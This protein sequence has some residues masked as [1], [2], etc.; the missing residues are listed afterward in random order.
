MII[1]PLF[2]TFVIQILVTI[3]A[4][5]GKTQAI[6]ELYFVF[7]PSSVTAQQGDS[8]L[9]PCSV[10]GVHPINLTW[11]QGGEEL[12][13]QAG[14]VEILPNGSLSL[15]LSEEIAPGTKEGYQCCAS[16]VFGKL[17]SPAVSI[18]VREPLRKPVI[19]PSC[20]DVALNG[21]I[22]LECQSNASKPHPF[23]W[24][25]DGEDLIQDER[26]T[27]LP[28][29]VLQITPVIWEDGGEYRCITG[30]PATAL[31]TSESSW[32]TVMEELRTSDCSNGTVSEREGRLL[33]QEPE[34]VT[35][36]APV[37]VLILECLGA[38][39]WVEIQW[40]RN[41]EK[42]L[43]PGRSHFTGNKNLKLT[44]L[45][46]DDSG[47]YTCNASDTRTGEVER[48]NAVVQIEDVF[49]PEFTVRPTSD[50]V[51]YFSTARLYCNADGKP[52]PQI[53]WYLNGEPI[54][55]RLI[56]QEMSSSTLIIWNV[57]KEHAGI[58]QCVVSNSVGTIQ[59]SARLTVI[60][61]LNIPDPPYNLT[62]YT[63]DSSQILITWQADEG[64]SLFSLH[65]YIEPDGEETQ[66]VM[67]DEH[68]NTHI[69]KDL[70]PYTN[71]TFY[72]RAY[73][74]VASGISERVLGQTAEGVPVI[75][76]MFSLT[77]SRGNTIFV[78]WEPITIVAL[79]RGCIS[80]YRVCY[81]ESGLPRQYTC[82]EV[83]GSESS[84]TLRG[85]KP[86][87]VYD[88]HMAV[89]TSEGFGPESEVQSIRTID[90]ENC[91]VPVMY[92][93]SASV[94]PNDVS[95]EASWSPR[96]EGN[97]VAVL[98]FQLS[99]SG[100]NHDETYSLPADCHSFVFSDLL[101]GERYTVELL[102]YNDCGTGPA[103]TETF[104]LPSVT[105]MMYPPPENV[106][107]TALS[108]TSIQLNW[109][110]V[111]SISPAYYQILYFQNSNR[112]GTT[113]YLYRTNTYVVLKDL[114]PYTIY[115]LQVRVQR[116]GV[117]GQFSDLIYCRTK[118][119]VPSE[120]I[121]FTAEPLDPHTVSVAWHPPLNPNGVIQGYNIMY[122]P[123]TQRTEKQ[124]EPHWNR[125]RK[126]GTATSSTVSNLTSD[127]RYYF[128]L[129]ACTSVGE[130]KPSAVLQ[131]KTPVKFL[132]VKTD[133]SNNSGLPS[134][135]EKG[136]VIG[137]LLG[138]FCIVLCT[139]LAGIR[140]RRYDSA[141]KKKMAA[142]LAGVS[143]R[144]GHRIAL[145]RVA[146]GS[147]VEMA[148]TPLSPM[149]TAEVPTS[150]PN[151]QVHCD[152]PL[153][154]VGHQAGSANPVEFPSRED[155]NGHEDP[156]LPQ[157]SE[158]APLQQQYRHTLPS[159]SSGRVAGS[160]M[161]Q[162]TSL[163]GSEDG[164]ESS[165]HWTPLRESTSGDS[166]LIGDIEFSTET[167]PDFIEKVL[168]DHHIGIHPV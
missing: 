27:L 116:T 63:V 86:A 90:N 72:M 150:Q 94:T 112:N 96:N 141:H 13:S 164:T 122:V 74:T 23:L 32:V 158:Q 37:D 113:K 166:G 76:P 17:C 107:A 105:G 144:S 39:N 131:V 11:R 69:V 149:L 18:V 67:A 165:N 108:S 50:T 14:A 115:A 59:T 145:P 9:L 44:N 83:D 161:N 81:Q 40:S 64:L 126:K 140:Y 99:F 54:Q 78:K 42:A 3:A 118:E 111:L 93:L 6:P 163:A 85:L 1:R 143:G 19:L 52:K 101:T 132:D 16:N 134:D 87:T 68:S 114:K 80:K 89:A 71:Y 91:S 29:G 4:F 148:L 151:G 30:N 168:R 45:T 156:E 109:D 160:R 47:V 103:S 77:S 127:T 154:G 7:L 5:D 137:I 142:R 31:T 65:Y 10:S 162:E 34:D 138:T 48:A 106:R 61:P 20:L 92:S 167:S 25:K 117:I 26:Y 88:V 146:Q 155:G 104:T 159:T 100:A 8:V 79:I 55:S 124:E 147:G 21:S 58:Y 43:P 73:T 36:I 2:G 70:L 128:F 102:A 152:S 49:P 60:L 97:E 28:D 123:E 56:G 12:S 120:P 153:L 130:G 22:R 41:G 53:S 33:L 136:L 98:G 84:Y 125:T 15:N 121:G 38:G 129:R 135:T 46:P 139:V 110:P 24:Q 62:T 95:I 57:D 133:S 51:P 157:M 75:A 82:R 66:L 119:D 35:M